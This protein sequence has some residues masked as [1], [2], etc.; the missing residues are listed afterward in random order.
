MAGHEHNPNR[1]V[2]PFRFPAVVLY[3]QDQ[4]WCLVFAQFGCAAVPMAHL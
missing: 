4:E 1:G 3:P 2:N